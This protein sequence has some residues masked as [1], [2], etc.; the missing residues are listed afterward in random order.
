MTIE[1]ILCVVLGVAGVGW[2]VFGLS[3]KPEIVGRN[4]AVR[5]M[6]DKQ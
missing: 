4:E 2:I 1:S 6:L 3:R 5:R